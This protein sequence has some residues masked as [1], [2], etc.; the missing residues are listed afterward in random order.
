MPFRLRELREARGMPRLDL[1]IKAGLNVNTVYKLERGV[2]TP[3]LDTLQR[4]ARALGVRP[5]ELHRAAD[6]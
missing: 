6:L 4:L 5:E 3:K 2:A 1:A